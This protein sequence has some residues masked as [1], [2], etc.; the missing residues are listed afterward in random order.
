MKSLW[1]FGMAALSA[2]A[3]AKE[4]A[5]QSYGEPEAAVVLRCDHELHRVYFGAA[6]VFGATQ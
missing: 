5:A 6:S 4:G 3:C 2:A 1:A